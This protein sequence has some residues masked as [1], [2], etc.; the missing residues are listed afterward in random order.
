MVS[1]KKYSLLLIFLPAI[2]APQDL[3]KLNLQQAYDLSQKNYPVIKEKDLI[4][5]TSAINIA[6]LQKGFLPQV[7]ISG[8]ATYQSDV[9]RIDVSFP[10]FSFNPPGKDQYKLVADVSQ[11]I[12]DGGVT[13][14]QKV[15]QRLNASVEDQKVEVELYKLKERV[16]QIYLSILYLDEQLK[17]VDLVKADIQTGIKR[18][19]AQVQ[20]GV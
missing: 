7:A 13:K 18:L 11:L 14:E 16:N 15:L 2:A 12:Y 10:G 3:K 17:Q 9:T 20:N 6:N 1:L 5:Q 8:Q 19:E 4:S